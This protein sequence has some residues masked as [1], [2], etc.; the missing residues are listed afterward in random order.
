MSLCASAVMR[1]V[2]PPDMAMSSWTLYFD[3]GNL[4]D[5]VISLIFFQMLSPS[6]ALRVSYA[7]VSLNLVLSE[8]NFFQV[9][10]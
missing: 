1:T 5:W 6:N 3:E 8:T 4:M 7:D 9:M 10:N 2:M